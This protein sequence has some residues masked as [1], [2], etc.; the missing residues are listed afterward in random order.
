MLAVQFLQLTLPPIT[1]PVVLPS[2][3]EPSLPDGTTTVAAT[4]TPNVIEAA[5]NQ[6]LD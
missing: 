6:S 3:A 5:S 2:K 1:A 4:P